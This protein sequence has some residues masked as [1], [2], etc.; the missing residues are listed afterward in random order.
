[1][2]KLQKSFY[3]S[4]FLYHPGSDQILLQQPITSPNPSSWALFEGPPVGQETPEKTFQRL[5][6]K[7]LGLKLNLR[8][9]YP[10]YFYRG[11]GQD[12]HIIYA[13]IKTANAFLSKKGIIFGW[14]SFKQV[15]KLSLSAQAKHDVAVAQR[16][17]AASVRKSLGQQTLT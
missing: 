10:V 15:N 5:V 8:D 14:F 2:H 9:I 13:Q 1:M 16:V 11:G 3:A 6:G 12:R 7:S 17:I 4:G